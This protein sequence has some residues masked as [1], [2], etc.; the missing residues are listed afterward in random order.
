VNQPLALMP[1]EA[2]ENS[3][4]KRILARM[5]AL[6]CAAPNISCDGVFTL[7][8]LLR[9]LRQ[10]RNWPM[11]RLRCRVDEEKVGIVEMGK[12]PARMAGLAEV[13]SVIY[14]WPLLIDIS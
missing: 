12:K 9:V 14:T 11:Q 8:R 3:N 13:A 10:A 1:G 4:R 5:Q 2:P 6:Y 7:L